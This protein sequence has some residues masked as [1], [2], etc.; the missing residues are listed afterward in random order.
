MGC[1]ES[2]ETPCPQVVQAW[3][4]FF[5]LY[6]GRGWRQGACSVSGVAGGSAESAGLVQSERDLGRPLPSLHSPHPLLGGSLAGQG[7]GPLLCPYR[8][9]LWGRG[10]RISGEHAEWAGQVQ[11]SGQ[12]H[13]GESPGRG[14]GWEGGG[15]HCAAWWGFGWAGKQQGRYRQISNGGGL[16]QA[17]GEKNPGAQRVNLG[18]GAAVLWGSTARGLQDC[19]E[20][21]R[22]RV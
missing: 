6:S 7:R 13:K 18:A 21:V 4:V 15:G 16:R 19:L 12:Q 20:T 1:G 17:R 10:L 2:C 9:G 3:R 5:W 11:A 8:W 14:H 22:G